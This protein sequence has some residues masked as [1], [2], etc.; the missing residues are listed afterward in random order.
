MKI[1]LAIL[2]TA[3]AVLL[4]LGGHHSSESGERPPPPEFLNTV[5]D[6][7]R[8]EFWEIVKNRA[9]PPEEKKASVLEWGKK[10]NLETQ[11]Q[12]HEAMIEEWR[13]THP[14]PL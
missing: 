12:Q 5:N 9:L 11:A 10:Y 4:V 2:V 13:K 14:M 8:K 1:A 6:T 7:V 3:Y